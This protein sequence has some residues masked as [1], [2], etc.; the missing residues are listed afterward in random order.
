MVSMSKTWQNK[1]TNGIIL[2][3]ALKMSWKDALYIIATRFGDP[4][5]KW[6]RRNKMAA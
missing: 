6:Q 2:Y 4:K 5:N 1:K 3:S